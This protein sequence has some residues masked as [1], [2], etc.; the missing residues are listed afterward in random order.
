M[1]TEVIQQVITK[2]N[3]ISNV[4][5]VFSGSSGD[6]LGSALAL[7]TFL[8]KLEKEVT[9]VSSSP[10]NQKFSF[11]SGFTDVVFSLDLKKSFVIDINTQ[12]KAIEELSYKKETDKL[13]IWHTG[14][15]KGLRYQTYGD[16]FKAD[17]RKVFIKAVKGMLPKNKIQKKRLNNLFVYVGNEHP[18]KAQE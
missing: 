14:F 3:Q 6:S 11:L 12:K 13:Y 15:P 2:L 5:I 16:K 9:I 17:P 1:A 18:H 4:L 7:K 10:L 8:S